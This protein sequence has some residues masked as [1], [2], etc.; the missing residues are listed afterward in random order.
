[1]IAV[2]IVRNTLSF[3]IYRANGDLQ[4]SFSPLSR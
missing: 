1:M 4:R 3:A 2:I